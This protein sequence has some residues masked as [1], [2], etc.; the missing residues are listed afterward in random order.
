MIQRLFVIAHYARDGNARVLPHPK[1]LKRLAERIE[2]ISEE[3]AGYN[4]HPVLG[5]KESLGRD[6]NVGVLFDGLPAVLASY[7]GHLRFIAKRLGDLGK[8]K[9]SHAKLF[10]TY[11]VE[12][13]KR[14]TGGEHYEEIACLFTAA[15]AALGSAKT[16]EPSTLRMLVKRYRRSPFNPGRKEYQSRDVR[17]DRESGLSEVPKRLTFEQRLGEQ[18]RLPKP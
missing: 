16:T 4:S 1:A 13:A 11:F 8:T 17:A 6:P 5:W 12:Y 7:S 18:H 14:I 3:I 9:P 15:E 10:K 2:F